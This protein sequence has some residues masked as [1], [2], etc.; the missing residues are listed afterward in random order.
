MLLLGA[1]SCKPKKNEPW[2]SLFD[3]QTL[4]GW[5]LKNGNAPYTII[6][7]E[8]IGTTVMDSPNT[9]LCTTA[10]YSDFILEFDVKV[11]TTINSGVQ[12]RS[13]SFSDYNEGQVHGYQIE[14]DP[15]KRAWSGGVYDEGRRGWLYNLEANTSGRSAFKNGVWN[16][17]RVEAIEDKFMVWVN[18]INTT[19]LRDNMTSKG[20]IGLQVHSIS[21]SI[22]AGKEIRWRNI[23]IIT[24]DPKSYS[25][26]PNLTAALKV[27]S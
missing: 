24:D 17:Y 11:D 15:S 16:H 14:I 26:E 3:G 18:N 6:N 27:T 2:I 25:W 20:F 8:I 12:I 13:N 22:H 7:E 23:K 1:N 21:D 4:D 10:L 9:F 5:E 19:N